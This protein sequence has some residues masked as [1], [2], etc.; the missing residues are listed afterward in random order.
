MSASIKKLGPNELLFREGD[1]SD[2]MY[3]VKSGRLS[4]FK[5]KGKAEIQLAELG[6]GAMLGEMAFFDNKPRS[7][8]AKATQD[9]EVIILPF[10]ALY[11]QFKT[12]PEW[13]KSV[14]KTINDHLR[15]ANQ[16]I[17]NLEQAT[18]DTRMFPPHTITKLCGILA[19]VAHKYGEAVPEGVVVPGGTL[20]KF[21]IQVFGEPTNRMQKLTEQLSGLGY[22]KVEDLGE[23][24][25]RMTMLKLDQLADFVEFYNDYLFKD[26]GK[27]VTIEETELKVLRALIAFGSQVPADESGKV[28]ISL[29]NMQN[30][31]M[32]VLGHL[33]T[34][35]D[36]NGLISKGVIGDKESQKGEL[37]TSFSLK[38][39]QRILP[40]W[41]LIYT[42]EKVTR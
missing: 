29:N 20:R 12:F 28:K 16:R 21:T 32:K 30:E 7:A 25:Q 40:F 31:S 23:G 35:N 36:V 27:R 42:L 14:V 26:E 19:L 15:E 5:A 9:S 37:F 22:M 13:L 17:K 39:L 3:V 34:A 41:E 18:N 11:A 1:P 24:K 2:A 4:V 38:D 6:P 33:V 8:S 10:K